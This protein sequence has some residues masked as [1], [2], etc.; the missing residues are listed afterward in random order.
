MPGW[1]AFTNDGM[2]ILTREDL[3][4]R[5][6][7]LWLCAPRQPFLPRIP[8]RREFGNCDICENPVVYDPRM[9]PPNAVKVCFSC[10]SAMMGPKH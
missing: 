5:G 8:D 6:Q 1:V 2:K 4:K 10:F 3:E 7:I 9:P